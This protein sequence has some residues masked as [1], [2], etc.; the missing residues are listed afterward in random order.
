MQIG[1]I[2]CPTPFL[3]R[4]LVACC[5]RV[6][7]CVASVVVMDNS[8]VILVLYIP[9]SAHCLYPSARLCNSL[10]AYS[11]LVPLKPPSEPRAFVLVQASKCT[12]LDAHQ[13]NCVQSYST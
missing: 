11:K 8:F 3:L 1:C 13:G 7:N 2:D 5:R 9:Y 4:R 6:L 10:E 12:F